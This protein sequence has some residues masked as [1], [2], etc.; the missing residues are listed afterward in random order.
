[1]D[2][3]KYLKGLLNTRTYRRAN[4]SGRFHTHMGKHNTRNARAYE[5]ELLWS[6]PQTLGY[7]QPQLLVTTPA[8]AAITIRSPHRLTAPSSGHI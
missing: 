5:S 7:T 3:S 2:C 4:Y 1:M 8:H 6:P